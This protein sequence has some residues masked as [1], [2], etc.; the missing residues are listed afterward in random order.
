MAVF[1]T[2][3]SHPS[4]TEKAR[5]GLTNL[6]EEPR[7]VTDNAADSACGTPKKGAFP[8]GG[9]ARS[10]QPAVLVHLPQDEPED[11]RPRAYAPSQS[12]F[13]LKFAAAKRTRY[14]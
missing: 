9:R 11:E 3:H 6:R 1:L 12:A 8:E 4:K 2:I 5:G 7:R 10:G 13:R 14:G